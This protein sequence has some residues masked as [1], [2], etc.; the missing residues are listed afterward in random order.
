[1]L[2]QNL[3]GRGG[4]R[5]HDFQI[6]SLAGYRLPYSAIAPHP[7]EHRGEAWVGVVDLPRVELG[8]RPVP[9]CGFRR[10]STPVSSPKDVVVKCSTGTHRSVFPV[11][12]ERIELPVP[13]GG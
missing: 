11:P 3:R 2:D 5:T 9:T 1:M 6:M 13:E 10:R 8:S 12:S 7:F 4:I